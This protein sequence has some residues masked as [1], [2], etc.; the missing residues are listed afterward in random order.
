MNEEIKQIKSKSFI[1]AL[2]LLG[3]SGYSAI[4]GFTA[5]FVLTLKSGIHLLG[6]YSTV[7]AMLA[8]FNYF[9]DLGL[10]AAILQKKDIE[11][12]DLSSAF[13]IQLTLVTIAVIVGFFF[14]PHLFR[15]Y[16]DLPHNAIYLYW[17]ILASFFLLSLKSIPSVLLEKRLEIYKVVFVQAIEN[18]V[19]YLTVIVLVFMGYDIFS[20]V[21][22]VL[23][24]AVV[25]LIA[26]YILNPFRPRLMFSI[27][28]AKALLKY[29]IPFQSNSF[30]ALVKDDLLVIYLGSTIGLTNLGYV[31]FG[32]KYAEFSIRLIMDNINRVAFPLFA[33]FQNEKDLLKK[34]LHKVLFYETVLIFP[35]IIGAMFVF[36]GVL[37]I[38]PGYFQKWHISLFSFYFFSASAFFISMSTPFINLFN[39]IGKVKL[40]VYFMILWTVT[41]WTLVP[42]FIK[43]FGYNGISIAF[44]IMS[45]TFVLVYMQARRFVSFSLLEFIKE[46]VIATMA[47]TLYLAIVRLLTVNTSPYFYVFLSVVGGGGIYFL[48]L[49]RLKGKTLYTEFLDLLKMQK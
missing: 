35:F 44:F 11:E 8:F 13:F 47:M 45:L 36:D 31:M 20:L 22:A 2:S 15:L 46:N 27:P 4:L 19:F 30:L 16:K 40:S 32:K 38:I 12:V 1:S 23:A 41:L 48:V 28:A 24:R 49:Y 9:T 17:A 43:I 25:G 29:G 21:V 33:R 37:K 42:L 14:S 26:I 3:Q 10:A 6:I 39:A 34:S 7:L 18:T 5:F